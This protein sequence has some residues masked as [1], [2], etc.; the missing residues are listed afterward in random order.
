MGF[1]RD[2]DGPQAHFHERRV[3]VRHPRDYP[4][5]DD[6]AG[7]VGE[8]EVQ[9]VLCSMEG[10]HSGD[11]VDMLCESMVEHEFHKTLVL[12]NVCNIVLELGPIV[13][14]SEAWK[15]EIPSEDK[16]VG[17]RDP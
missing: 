6:R 2:S 3:M 10:I 8:Q 14:P 12:P 17:P 13:K 1:F 5:R 15:V 11:I 9:C 16:A 7:S 4:S